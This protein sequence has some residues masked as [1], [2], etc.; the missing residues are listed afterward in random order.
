MKTMVHS[1]D[2]DTNFFDIVNEIL[3]GDSLTVYLFLL[4]LD[5]RHQMSMNVIKEN[6]FALKKAR[7][8]QYPA[9]TITDTSYL[10][11]VMSTYTKQRHG[12][13]LTGYRSNGNLIY[14]IK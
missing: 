1:P 4:S 2:G 10:L 7:S 3:Q 12:V 8:K 9:E 11:K 5:Y 14:L 6:S 13:L